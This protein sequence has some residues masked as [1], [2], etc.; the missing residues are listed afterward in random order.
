M[1]RLEEG[2]L[3]C[4]SCRRVRSLPECCGRPMDHD[5]AVLFCPTCG[6]EMKTPHCCGEVMN[7]HY[8]VRDIKKEI[9]KD[10]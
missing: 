9:F 8:E 5:G 7:V 10:L 2:E 1:A 6:R 4:P 3:V